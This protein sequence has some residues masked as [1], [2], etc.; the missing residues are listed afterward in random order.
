MMLWSWRDRPQAEQRGLFAWLLQRR[1]TPEQSSYRL[2]VI[3]HKHQYGQ[4]EP[5]TLERLREN[6]DPT[7]TWVPMRGAQ[8]DADEQ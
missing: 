1:R 2:A 5:P 8:R 6:R 3:R 7:R 4:N